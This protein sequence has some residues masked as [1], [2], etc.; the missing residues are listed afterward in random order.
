MALTA[1]LLRGDLKRAT[2]CRWRQVLILMMTGPD[3]GGD[4]GELGECQEVGGP[5]TGQEPGEGG[6]PG[7][8]Q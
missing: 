3:L 5:D 6:D 4:G 8:G 2:A 1:T 7:G